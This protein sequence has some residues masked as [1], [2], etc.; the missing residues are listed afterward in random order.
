MKSMLN[1]MIAFVVMFIITMGYH[2]FDTRY[3]PV[4]K[5]FT[6]TEKTLDGKHLIFSGSFD[7]VK[8]CQLESLRFY[9]DFDG[10]SY[11]IHYEFLDRSSSGAIQSRPLGQQ[12]FSNWKIHL[13]ELKGEVYL[14]TTHRCN[15]FWVQQSRLFIAKI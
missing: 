1:V 8:N 7:K 2:H 6:V 14:V 9:Q 10:Y 12:I 13:Y 11:I 5:D 3:L 4:V 15:Q